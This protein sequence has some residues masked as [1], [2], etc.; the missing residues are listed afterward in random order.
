MHSKH[1]NGIIKMKFGVTS[2][3]AMLTDY[4][5]FFLANSSQYFD[6]CYS[7]SLITEPRSVTAVSRRAICFDQPRLGDEFGGYRM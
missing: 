3:F 2:A 1:L 4:F 6:G 5:A 7:N